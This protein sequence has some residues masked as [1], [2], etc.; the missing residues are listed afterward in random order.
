MMDLHILSDP[1]TNF[2][3]KMSTKIQIKQF[4]FGMVV[5]W[6]KYLFWGE[7]GFFLS[8]LKKGGGGFG[9]PKGQILTKS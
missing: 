2:W 7:I 5:K 6:P 3:K 1:V 4:K 8:E 9:V